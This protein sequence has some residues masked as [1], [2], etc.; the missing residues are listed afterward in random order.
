MI[1]SEIRK[2]Y[3]SGIDI[4]QDNKIKNNCALTISF[5]DKD[6]NIW[7][8]AK[9]YNTTVDAIREENG[10]ASDVLENNRMLMIPS[11]NC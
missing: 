11:H 9:K 3:I 7:N 10:L 5:C 8:I 4:M 2:K 1:Y 6:E